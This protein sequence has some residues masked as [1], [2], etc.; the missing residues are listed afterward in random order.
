MK[1]AAYPQ[2]SANNTGAA[3]D[4]AMTNSELE[5]RRLFADVDIRR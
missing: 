1:V 4:D 3:G 5:P 2:Q